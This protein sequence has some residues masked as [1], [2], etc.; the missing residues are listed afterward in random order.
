MEARRSVGVA[1]R[2]NDGA[3]LRAARQEVQA[4]KVALGERGP[5]WWDDDSPDYTRHLVKNTPYA[6]WYAESAS[7]EGRE[8]ARDPNEQ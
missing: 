8:K 5:V 7:P 4:V 6:R 3:L 1:K 2:N